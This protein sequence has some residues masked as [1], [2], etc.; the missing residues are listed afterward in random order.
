[1]EIKKGRIQASG[2]TPFNWDIICISQ[3]F[4]PFDILV[5]IAVNKDFKPIKNPLPN[6]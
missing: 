4:Q 2:F 6:E 1:M 3:G 5:F